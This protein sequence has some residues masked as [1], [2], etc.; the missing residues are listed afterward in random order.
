MLDT[1]MAR[2]ATS[3]SRSPAPARGSAARLYPMAQ[4]KFW[5]ITPEVD[6]AMATAAGTPLRSLPSRAT[7]L[8]AMATSEPV[9]TAQPTSAAARAGASFTPS[10]TIT[11]RCPWRC[12]SRSASSLPAGLS[13]LST[14]SM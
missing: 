3:G 13:A 1:P 9:P 5:T 8:V 7:S 14:W 4:P 12:M 10:P 2:A 11:T 6:A